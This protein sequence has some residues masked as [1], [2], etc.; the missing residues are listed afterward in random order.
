MNATQKII[1]ELRPLDLRSVEFYDVAGRYFRRRL[2]VIRNCGLFFIFFAFVDL[3]LVYVL[4]GRWLLNIGNFVSCPISAMIGWGPFQV[5]R[6]HI[7]MITTAR[8]AS[9]EHRLNALRQ[10]ATGTFRGDAVGAFILER[11]ND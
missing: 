8:K 2:R 9:T 7:L 11:F 4:W 6:C 3:V 10:L 1:A 5:G